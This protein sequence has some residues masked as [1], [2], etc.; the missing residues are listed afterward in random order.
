MTGAAYLPI[1][2]DRYVIIARQDIV[3]IEIPMDYRICLVDR[4]DMT[5]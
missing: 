2:H 3:K 1:E 4:I 5:T